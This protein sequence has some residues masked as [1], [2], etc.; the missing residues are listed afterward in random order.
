MYFLT[1][2]GIK[3]EANEK[4][5]ENIYYQN[6]HKACRKRYLVRMK[7]IGIK[8]VEISDCGDERDCP[9]IKR[10]KKT[11]LIDEIPELPLPG[12]TAPYC[13]CSY[14]AKDIF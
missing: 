7:S 6:Y 5:L 3:K 11:W 8:K 9:K 12:C 1:D 10:L 14:I 4:L 13:R 2:E